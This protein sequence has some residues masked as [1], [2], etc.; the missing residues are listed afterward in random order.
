[1]E[2]STT[3]PHH[4]KHPRPHGIPIQSK[5]SKVILGHNPKHEVRVMDHKRGPGSLVPN[6]LVHEIS[7]WL[8]GTHIRHMI[9]TA[10]CG[11]SFNSWLQTL[12]N[13]MLIPPKLKVLNEI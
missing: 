12:F 7:V 5:G 9:Q 4:V 8:C 10:D 3:S 1:M 13:K 6:Q 11:M 2:Q